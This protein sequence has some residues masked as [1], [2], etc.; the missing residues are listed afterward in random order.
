MG[1]SWLKYKHNLN[2]QTLKQ[3]QQWL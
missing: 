1:E 2:N 3:Q